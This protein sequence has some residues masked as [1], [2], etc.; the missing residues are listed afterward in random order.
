MD[1]FKFFK[2]IK[3]LSVFLFVFCLQLLVHSQVNGFG[4]K[5]G[6]SLG[7]QKWGGSNQRD[8]LLRWHVA[9][10]FDSESSDSKNVIYSQLGY[11][12]KGGGIRFPFS[13]DQHGNRLPGGTYGME[14]HN[15]SLDLGLK[16]FI[17][18]GPWKPYYAVGIRGEY[19]VNT[20]FEIYEN[21][22]EWTCK[23]NYGISIKLGSE[24][25]FQKFIHGGIELN[26]A[27]DLSKQIYVPASIRRINPW[28]GQAEPG[29]EQSTVNTTLELS[30]YLRF[31]QIIE[32]E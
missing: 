31:L 7:Y 2:M 4:I 21:L 16:R 8:P 26:I 20:H 13:I 27:P 11:H 19:T 24:F 22:Q 1:D 14:F 25:K 5:G 9:I 23:W 10:F 3:L 32:Y 28:T 18:Q 30:L 6:P 17:K 12:V 29:Y 15:I